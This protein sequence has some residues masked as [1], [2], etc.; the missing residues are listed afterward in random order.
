MKA[1]DKV[2]LQCNLK[3]IEGQMAWEIIIEILHFFSFAGELNNT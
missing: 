2:Q 1:T 3:R